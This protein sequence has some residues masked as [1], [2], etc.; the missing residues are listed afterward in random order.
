MYALVD[1]NSFYVSCERVF[2]PSLWNRPTIVLSNNDGCA[3]ARSREAKDLGIGMEPYFKIKDLCYR[4]NVAVLSSN[5]TLYGDMSSRVMNLLSQFSSRISIYSID[6]AFIKLSDNWSEKEFYNYAKLMSDEILKCTGIPVSIGIA[7]SKSLAKIAAS[8]AKKLENNISVLINEAAQKQVLESLA[9][10]DIWGIGKRWARRLKQLGIFTG[11]QLRESSE[12]LI[13]KEFTIIG[14]KLLFELRGVECFSFE[15]EEVQTRR[16]VVSSR[17]FGREVTSF[18]ELEEALSEYIARAGEKLRY[19]K[20]LAQSV[21]VFVQTNRFRDK[22]YYNSIYG[23]LDYATSD[24]ITIIKRA[25]ELLSQLYQP[26]KRYKKCGVVLFNLRPHESYQLTFAEPVEASEKRNELYQAMDKL[27]KKY[28]RN[29]LRIA[30]QG[31]EQSWKMNCS[32]RSKCYTTKWSE[33]PEAKCHN[34]VITSSL[35]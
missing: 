11:L 33:L 35:L 1:C 24:I 12:S 9:V 3:I 15:E 10:E 26:G 31:I 16:S 22:Q 5:Y 8:R 21:G 13:R 23:E 7:S 20:M 18:T 6:E 4:H 14:K 32:Y 28:G 29:T 27:N 2:D 34:T 19:N 25:K 30:A 17:S